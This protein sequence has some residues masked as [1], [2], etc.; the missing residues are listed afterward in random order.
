MD[1]FL[2][3]DTDVHRKIFGSRM[4]TQFEVWGG[5]EARAWGYLPGDRRAL[6]VFKGLEFRVYPKGPI[7]RYSVLR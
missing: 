1:V 5:G 4:L 6:R 7:I 2:I 3:Q